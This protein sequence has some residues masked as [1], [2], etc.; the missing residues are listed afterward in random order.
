VL[1]LALDPTPLLQLTPEELNKKLYLPSSELGEGEQRLPIKLLHVNKCPIVAPAKTL[2]AA[3][4]E[5]QAIDRNKCLDNLKIIVEHFSEISSKILTM[6]EQQNTERLNQEDKNSDPDFAIYS[7]GFFSAKDKQLMEEIKR[8]PAEKLGESRWEFTDERLATMLFRYRGRN[9]PQTLD[10]EEMLKWQRFR[11]YRLTDPDSPGS[12]KMQS[13][14][15]EVEVLLAET[16]E[17]PKKQS[18][19]KA[20]V[21]YAQNL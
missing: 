3:N 5:R 7:G 20:L 13:F 15:Q 16:H 10:N 6:F 21:Q 4:S 17:N 11:Q 12:I 14:M 2:T 1:N 8:T 18:I 19:L 9:F